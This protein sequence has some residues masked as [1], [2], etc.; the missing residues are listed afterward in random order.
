MSYAQ[1]DLRQLKRLDAILDAL[2]QFHQLTPWSDKRLIAGEE[3]D[4]EIRSRLEQMDIFLFVASQ[5]SLTRPYIRDPEI[6]RAQVRHS[7]GKIHVVT[8]K[9]EPCACD[10]HPFLRQLH[11]LASG[12]RS[13]AETKIKATIWEQVRTDLIPVIQKARTRNA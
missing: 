1:D 12:Y 5:I 10:E 8:L 4:K 3:W 11:R 6:K 7:E 2:E 9:L 13:V